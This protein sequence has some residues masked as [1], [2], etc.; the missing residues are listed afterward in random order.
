MKK[1]LIIL[2]PTSTGKTDLALS[3]ARKLNGELIACDSRQVYKGLDLGAGKYPGVFSKTIKK[4][5]F[6]EVDGIKIHLY[7]VIDPSSQFNV[8]DYVKLAKKTIYK[9]AKT[10]K[11]P[12]ITAG[13]GLYL[14]ALLKGLDS[15]EVPADQKLRAKLDLLE[16]DE[17]QK[18]LIILNRKKY[19][20]MNN[21][22]RQNKRRLIRAI[23]ISSLNLNK[24]ITKKQNGLGKKFSILKIGLS[25][26]KELINQRIDRR[27]MQRINQGLI[28]EANNLYEK[29]LSLIRMRELGLEYA[30]L[31]DFL[32]GKLTKKELVEKL[33]IKIHQFAKRQVT[34]FKKEA[35][36]NWFDISKKNY[37][38]ELEKTILKWYH[39]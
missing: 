17:L 29:G 38:I 3:L 32:E 9:I 1:L 5:S 31:A 7:D 15:L 39:T 20:N 27:V 13:T 25:T 28:L 10:N 37:R 18:K 12:I 22:D 21:S 30:C 11:L 2:G 36:V 23:E 4:K 24:V 6:W 16:V 14:K 34:W 35:E 8:S 19:L 26:K 33:K